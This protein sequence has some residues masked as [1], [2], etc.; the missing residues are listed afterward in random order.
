MIYGKRFFNNLAKYQK[1][2]IFLANSITVEEIYKETV[3]SFVINN[4]I[5]IGKKPR[6]L[7]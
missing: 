3:L 5:V 1:I 7:N 4:N 2:N 6:Q